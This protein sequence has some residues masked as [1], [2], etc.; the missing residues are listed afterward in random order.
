[1]FFFFVSQ[2]HRTCVYALCVVI[3]C[4]RPQ[5]Y[6]YDSSS[7]ILVHYNV[8]FIFFIFIIII[9]HHRWFVLLLLLYLQCFV[10]T[11]VQLR[12]TLRT[13][14][15]PHFCKQKV[16]IISFTFSLC[17]YYIYILLISSVYKK[18]ISSDSFV[19]LEDYYSFI[20]FF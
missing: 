8:Y 19:Q 17:V 2:V 1:M 3:A 10:I 16:K 5:C 14:L 18:G 4:C 20:E 7:F 9:N 12:Y 11:I 6:Y 13:R 15:N